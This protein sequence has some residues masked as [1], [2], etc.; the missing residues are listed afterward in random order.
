MLYSVVEKA[1]GVYVD[2][3]GLVFTHNKFIEGKG[4]NIIWVGQTFFI[5]FFQKDDTD[6]LF[7]RRLFKFCPSQKMKIILCLKIVVKAR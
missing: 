7:L 2:K 4:Q 5:Y 1:K 3:Q 6:V